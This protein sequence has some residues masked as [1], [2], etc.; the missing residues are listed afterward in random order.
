[1]VLPIEPAEVPGVWPVY[2]QYFAREGRV[3]GFSHGSGRNKPRYYRPQ[4]RP[5]LPFEIAKLAEADDGAIVE[6]AR[7]WG[8]LGFDELSSDITFGLLPA[9]YYA[10][11]GWERRPGPKG[12]EPF[13][14]VRMHGRELRFCT[15]LTYA[16]IIGDSAL[17]TSAFDTFIGAKDGMPRW[18]ERD[19]LADPFYAA[20]Y[21][22]DWRLS[23]GIK[24]IHPYLQTR[25]L[26]ES[27]KGVYPAIP[28]RFTAMIEIAY[29]HAARL[30]PEAADLDRCKQCGALFRRHDGRQRFCP[31]R[32]GEEE[33][34]CSY[35]YRYQKLKATG[36]YERKK[37]DRK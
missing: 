1:M 27:D 34:R 3:A 29:L 2:D 13:D 17:V 20:D 35:R 23:A 10:L 15:S 37:G 12:W 31:P 19:A 18:M 11:E 9:G 4:D 22:L 24:G 16:R 28:Y 30:L 25:P 26:S 32:E 33:S 6:F 21:E 7:H 5:D 14:F 8:L 36:Y